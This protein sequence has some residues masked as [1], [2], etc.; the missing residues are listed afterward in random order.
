MCIMFHCIL[1]CSNIIFCDF[2][3][4]LLPIAIL[5]IR[6]SGQIVASNHVRRAL[7][8]V[9]LFVVLVAAGTMLLSFMGCD[10]DTGLG[11]CISMLSNIGPG[12]GTTGPSSNFAHLPAASKW[13][14]S[15]YMLIGR[16]EFFTVLFLFMP[17]FWKERK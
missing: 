6:V 3:M 16:L 1:I 17:R 7:A 14:L 9:V 8:Y 15:F 4:Q 5:G 10:V 2:L 12:T 11:S 13:L